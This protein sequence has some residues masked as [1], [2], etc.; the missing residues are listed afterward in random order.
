MLKLLLLQAHSR[1][2]PTR[3]VTQD[4]LYQQTLSVRRRKSQP[5][6]WRE[7]RQRPLATLDLIHAP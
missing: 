6:S 4:D 7:R 3:A 5:A 1:L 2:L